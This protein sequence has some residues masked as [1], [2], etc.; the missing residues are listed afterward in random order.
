MNK[1]RAIAVG[2]IVL[3]A[4][5][6]A[7]FVMAQQQ[8]TAPPR[9]PLAE[10]QLVETSQDSNAI[11]IGVLKTIVTAEVQYNTQHGSFVSWHELY[12]APE[13][14]KGWQPLHLSAGPEIIRGWTLSLVASAD[15]QSF[16]LS[17]RNLAD[18]CRLSFFSDQNG[19]I[20]EGGS[21]NCSVQLVPGEN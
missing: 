12:R 17:V 21:L 14:Q 5:V 11:G 3:G 10:T 19:I 7:A 8:K 9:I 13:V 4:S 2:I 18:P 15:G 6:C 20:Y 1:M 16:Q